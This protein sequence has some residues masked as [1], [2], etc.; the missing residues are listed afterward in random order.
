MTVVN[1]DKLFMKKNIAISTLTVLLAFMTL[2]SFVQKKQAD[3][4]GYRV[5]ECQREIKDNFMAAE[6][7]KVTAENRA[8]EAEHQVHL[9][10]ER[11][12][13]CK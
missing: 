4:L 5:S 7:N 10:K 9:L 13:N 12:K 3:K 2:A 6:K 11:L 1:N 8:I